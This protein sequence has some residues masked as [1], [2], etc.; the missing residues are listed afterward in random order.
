M[1]YGA[2]AFVEKLGVRFQID[3]DVIPDTRI[4]LALPVLDETHQPLFELRGLQ[5]FHDFPEGPDWWTLDDWKAI[6]GQAAKMRMNFVGLHT[7]P[8]QNKDLGP[9]P[10][11]WIGLH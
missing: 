4:P 7:Y 8:F 11:V 6:L 1:L 2:Y 10:T 9:E 3:G 5:P